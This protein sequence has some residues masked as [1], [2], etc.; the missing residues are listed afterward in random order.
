MESVIFRNIDFE[1]DLPLISAY[2]KDAYHISFGTEEPFGNDEDYFRWAEWQATLFPGMIA[3][4]EVDGKPAGMVEVQYI[5]ENDEHFG[6]VNLFYLEQDLRGKRLGDE[7][8][9]YV[10]GLFKTQ[11]LSYY[12]LRVAPE[13]LTALKFYQRHGFQKIAEESLAYPVYRFRK[14]L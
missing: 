9:K 2:R 7:Q 11:S 13:N 4:M 5:I 12:D 14:Y 8:I 6:Y 3:M 1:K 10:E